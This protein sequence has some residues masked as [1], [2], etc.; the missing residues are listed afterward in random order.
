MLPRAA[1]AMAVS[2]VQLAKRA[3]VT[4]ILA[5]AQRY[6]VQTSAAREKRR[7]AKL[8]CRPVTLASSRQWLEM[9][10]MQ[11]LFLQVRAAYSILSISTEKQ[12]LSYSHLVW[13]RK[14]PLPSSLLISGLRVTFAAL[15][16]KNSSDTDRSPYFH[17]CTPC[18]GPPG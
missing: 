12:E 9:Q 10:T 15:E 18:A 14:P 13:T 8:C 17:H 1:M 7:S 11:W 4:L 2:L 6:G 3:L 5:L 16:V